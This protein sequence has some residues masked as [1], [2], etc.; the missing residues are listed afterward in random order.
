MQSFGAR[1]TAV[2]ADSAASE[3]AARERVAATKGCV[4][5]EDGKEPTIAEG[6]GTVGVEAE[7]LR[8]GSTQWFFPSAM[9][10]SSPAWRAGSKSARRRP[11]SLVSALAARRAWP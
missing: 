3:A 9:A 5:V 1:V 6:A 2:G 4:Y 7:S 8:A 10:P 11:A